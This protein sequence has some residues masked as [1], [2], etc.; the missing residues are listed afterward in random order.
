M[1]K[2]AISGNIASGKS[3]VESILRE[4][5]YPVLDTDAVCHKLLDELPEIK[6]EFKGYDI[7]SASGE[8]SR[9]KLG[10]LVFDNADLKKRLENVL[11]PVVRSE[12]EKFFLKNKT[13][14]A[15]FVSVPLLFEANME[16]LFDKIIFIYCNDNIRLRR[17]VARNNYDCVYAQKRLDAQLPQ[18]EKAAKSDIVITNNNDKYALKKEIE[19]FLKTF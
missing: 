1:I 5:N 3:T 19:K 9:E 6:E 16:N 7:L 4:H 18:D 15:A 2:F 11:Y 8:I 17:L 13:Q 10:K 14:K 12:I